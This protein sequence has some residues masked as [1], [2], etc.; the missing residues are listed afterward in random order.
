VCV[1]LCA[2]M[3]LSF[4]DLNLEVKELQHVCMCVCMRTCVGVC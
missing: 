2:Y 3:C 1:C 4:C